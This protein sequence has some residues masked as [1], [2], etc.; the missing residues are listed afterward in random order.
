[1]KRK[2]AW[3]I[4]GLF[5]TVCFL[6][7]NQTADAKGHIRYNLSEDGVLSFYGRGELKR[8]DYLLSIE[9]D[10]IKKIVI[11]EGIT[12][13]G[14][15]SFT[16]FPNAKKVILPSSLKKIGDNVFSDMPALETIKVPDSVASIGKGAFSDCD[17]LKKLVLPASLKSWKKGIAQDCPSLSAIIN[18]SKVIC[19]LDNC[20]GWRIWKVNSKKTR[21]LPKKKT[22]RARGKKI[23]I[24]YD[25]AGGKR[26][27]KLPKYYEYGTKLTLPPNIKRN[28]YELLCWYSEERYKT[29]YPAAYPL[30][31]IDHNSLL[32]MEEQEEEN[33]RLEEI[34]LTPCWFKFQIQNS[35]EGTVQIYLDG[36]K[37]PL[38]IFMYEVRYSEFEDM[39]SPHS[40]NL[41]DAKDNKVMGEITNLDRGKIYYFEFRTWEDHQSEI[42]SWMGKRKI[43]V[44]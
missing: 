9:K 34:R 42:D 5:I 30:Y 23:P 8:A 6:T 29:F 38:D 18:R 20:R 26:T 41:L 14:K 43:Q 24:I 3:I 22:A 39:S 12:S 15:N 37:N 4:Y 28:G 7:T 21:V 16:Y 32:Y 25:L 10:C 36:S 1:M 13:L 2:I 11:G 19:H 27:G 35:K 17:L 31:Y 33:K 40:E 44:S